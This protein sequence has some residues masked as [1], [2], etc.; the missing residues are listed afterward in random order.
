MSS[1]STLLQSAEQAHITEDGDIAEG[2]HATSSAA[3]TLAVLDML[4]GAAQQQHQE[5]HEQLANDMNA[6]PSI[7]AAGN[8][9]HH[10]SS[11]HPSSEAAG[12]LSCSAIWSAA[13]LSIEH[14]QS[15]APL[16]PVISASMPQGSRIHRFHPFRRKSQAAQV[17]LGSQQSTQQQARQRLITPRTAV[18]KAQLHLQG[19][20]G[21]ARLQLAALSLAALERLVVALSTANI[22]YTHDREA[23]HRFTWVSKPKCCLYAYSQ[24][25][26]PAPL[27]HIAE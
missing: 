25:Q 11:K 6:Q 10:P 3:S 27:E 5:Q 22:R 13:W 15:P 12:V 9:H 8:I 7:Q 16:P 21:K 23:S 2:Q 24:A 14:A 17:R 4:L 19:L 18:K 1:S 26:V 20:E